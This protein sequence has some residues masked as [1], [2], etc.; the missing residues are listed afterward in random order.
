LFGE[1]LLKEAM[2]DLTTRHFYV[3]RDL[4]AVVPLKHKLSGYHARFFAWFSWGAGGI[5]IDF[6]PRIHFTKP[7]DKQATM[8]EL[9]L[10]RVGGVDGVID[11]VARNDLALEGR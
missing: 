8:Y 7:G 11:W 4:R 1:G 3:G 5:D 2:P 9:E 6:P 10:E